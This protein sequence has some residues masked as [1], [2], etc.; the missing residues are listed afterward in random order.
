MSIFRSAV[1]ALPLVLAGVCPALADGPPPAGE[2]PSDWAFKVGAGMM[3]A[4]T[5]EGSK[6]YHV[7]PI[8]LAE[9]SWRDTVMLSP[10]DG[11]KVVLRPLNDKGFSVSGGIGMWGGRKEGA[12]KDYDDALRGLGDLE[13]GAVARL[14]VDYRYKAVSA[15]LSLMRDLGGD[16]DGTALTLKGGYKIYDGTAFKVNADLS[17]TWADDNYM[18]SMF[19]ITSVQSA[20]SPRRYAVHDAG[21]GVKDVKFGLNANYAFTPAIGLFARAEYGRL[22]GDAADSPIVK[23]AGSENQMTGMLGLSYRF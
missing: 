7:T 16:R 23:D 14:G 9:V 5:Y 17:T 21:A 19:G 6:N 11:L 12:D 13:G 2:K 20:R 15:G 1:V 8:P 10:K 18:Q 3:V 22:L 4:P